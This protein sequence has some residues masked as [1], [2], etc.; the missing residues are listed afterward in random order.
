MGSND[1]GRN[2]AYRDEIYPGIA[3]DPVIEAYKKDVDVSLLHAM[4]ALTFEQRLL[5]LQGMQQAAEELAAAVR[6]RR[7]KDAQ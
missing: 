6:A 2:K 1:G 3:R 4:L 7:L 5:R